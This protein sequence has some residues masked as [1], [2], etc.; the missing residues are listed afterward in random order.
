MWKGVIGPMKKERR[1]HFRR[2]R[3]AN[4]SLAGNLF[5][6]LILLLMGVCLAIPLYYA[7]VSSLKPFEEIFVFPPK[8]YVVNPTMDNF[9]DLFQ[10]FANSTVPFSRYVFNS[11][12]VAV[13]CTVLHIFFSSMAAYPLA[14]T[15]F[16]VRTCC[17]PS[18]C[19]RCCSCRR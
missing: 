14:K 3:S 5:V 1:R 15:V 10:I 19:W 16:G 2:H 7:I 8:F 12:F 18:S 11:L 6:I 13:A 4:R 9:T 17:F